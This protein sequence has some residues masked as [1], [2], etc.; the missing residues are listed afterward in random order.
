[1]HVVWAQ[2]GVIRSVLGADAATHV[3][4]GMKK[5]SSE[6]WSMMLSHRFGSHAHAMPPPS[7]RESDVS[8][9][10]VHRYPSFC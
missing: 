8:S 10:R 1:M 5:K 3:M 9:G 2:A 4:K 7:P 6:N